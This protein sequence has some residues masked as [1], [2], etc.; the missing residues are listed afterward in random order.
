MIVI[1]GVEYL[2]PQAVAEAFGI[3]ADSVK[4]AIRRGRAEYIGLPSHKTRKRHGAE[5]APVRI[6]KRLYP[7]AAAAAKALNVTESTVTQ[8]LARGRADYIGLGR[9]RKHS[10]QPTTN[11]RCMKPLRIGAHSWP[12]R[13]AAAADLGIRPD[14]LGKLL[15]RSAHARLLVLAMQFEARR[16][17]QAIKAQRDEETRSRK[18]A[19]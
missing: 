6:R 13:R 7:S 11:T 18:D 5:P 3:T 8:M 4:G 1:R 12:S 16:T 10:Q 2:H 17:A 15:S 19:A 9:S 14:T